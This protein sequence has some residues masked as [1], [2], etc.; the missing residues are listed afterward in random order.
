M[1]AGQTRTQYHFSSAWKKFISDHPSTF[2]ILYIFRHPSSLSKAFRVCTTHTAYT[3][4]VHVLVCLCDNDGLRSVSMATRKRQQCWRC[5]WSLDLLPPISFCCHPENCPWESYW[6]PGKQFY[7]S[8]YSGL[9]S[10]KCIYLWLLN[11]IMYYKTN[12]YIA[13]TN[14]IFVTIYYNLK[15]LLFWKEHVDFFNHSQVSTSITF[16][17]VF[18]NIISFDQFILNW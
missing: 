16:D 2:S 18:R 6:N 15:L 3:P 11:N 1:L 9:Y 4:N 5:S 8:S 12:C 13:I 17:H 7:Q 10:S 14:V